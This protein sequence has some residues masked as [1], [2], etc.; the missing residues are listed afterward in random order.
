MW[1]I[2][3][4]AT[5]HAVQ[6]SE[7]W[8]IHTVSIR[9]GGSLDVCGLLNAGS[10]TYLTKS[11]APLAVGAV[12]LALAGGSLGCRAYW[13]FVSSG[14]RLS[15]GGVSKSW[16][17]PWAV[18]SRTKR[19]V[20]PVPVPTIPHRNR[21]TKSRRTPSVGIRTRIRI[22]RGPRDGGRY[23]GRTHDRASLQPHCLMP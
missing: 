22:R 9:R 3:R 4:Y 16:R 23:G 12:A 5:L 13:Y 14:S 15:A 10:H 6:S 1:P 2:P 7:K 18:A 20:P 21:E 8:E 17:T 19:W 11:T